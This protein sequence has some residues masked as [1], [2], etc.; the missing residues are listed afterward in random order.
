MIP[1]FYNV[2]P[3][4]ESKQKKTLYEIKAINI[5]LQKYDIVHKF[6]SLTPK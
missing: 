2:N 3:M 4:Y 6:T 5:P 1:K